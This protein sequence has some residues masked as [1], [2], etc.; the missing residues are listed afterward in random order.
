[1]IRLVLNAED[2]GLAPALTRRVLDLRARGH[3]S[4]VSVLAGGRSFGEAV[5]GLL[6]AGATGAGVHLCLVGGERPL[7]P[8]HLVPSLLAG[9][10]FRRG[11]PSVLAAVSAGRIRIAEVEREWEAQVERTLS[12]GLAATHLDSHQHL[13]LH[14]ALFPVAVRL[15]RRFRVPFVRAPRADDASRATD[16]T[17]A[18]RLRAHLLS[19]LGGRGRRLLSEAGLPDPPRVLGLAESGR[20][21]ERRLVRL[22]RALGPGDWEVVLHPG[23][24]DDATREDYR[25]GY[26]WREEADALASAGFASALS[27]AGATVASFADLAP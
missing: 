20:M 18:G 25:W 22:A 9:G 14:P 26:A 21:T 17:P 19:L 2:L 1:M 7:A 6:A 11:W 5:A 15:A 23:E 8:A 13:H 4:D 3:V 10:V 12:A 24:E 27:S 16:G